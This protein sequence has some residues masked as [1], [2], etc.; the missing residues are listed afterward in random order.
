MKQIVFCFLLSYPQLLVCSAIVLN[1]TVLDEEARRAAVTIKKAGASM[2][3]AL[4]QNNILNIGRSWC[5]TTSMQPKDVDRVGCLPNESSLD[6]LKGLVENCGAYYDLFHTPKEKKTI[7]S[8]WLKQFIRYV[9]MN[10][11]Q[12]SDKAKAMKTGQGKDILLQYFDEKEV[13]LAALLLSDKRWKYI[14][15]GMNE[16]VYENGSIAWI[17]GV[18][19]EHYPNESLS[20]PSH[21]NMCKWKL[22]ST[23]RDYPFDYNQKLYT[24]YNHHVANFIRCDGKCMTND[25]DDQIWLKNNLD[26][27]PYDPVTKEHGNFLMRPLPSYPWCISDATKV[28]WTKIGTHWSG[29]YIGSDEGR[30]NICRMY[31]AA[32]TNCSI[33]TCVETLDIKEIIL[34]NVLEHFLTK[35]DD[36]AVNA[37]FKDSGFSYRD[38][39]IFGMG[40]VV[41][42]QQ[43]I[44]LDK[45]IYTAL[46][47]IL[48]LHRI[49]EDS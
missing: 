36:Y 25:G 5:D 46:L 14:S 1:S 8:M 35:Y 16:K 28:G 49:R 27:A 37:H 44:S 9:Y 17:P 34:V 7:M 39:E 20:L 30:M 26:Y 6:V 13:S 24:F 33:Y 3:F 43:K 32:L 15:Y 12:F 40:G 45:F 4:C 23:S 22:W 41:A 19:Y 31:I 47:I 10:S 48:A 11:W 38:C 2:S 29:H 42:G 21:W 18:T